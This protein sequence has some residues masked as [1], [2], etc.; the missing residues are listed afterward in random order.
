MLDYFLTF[1]RRWLSRP[2]PS[3]MLDVKRILEGVGLRTVVVQTSI[4]H[5][6]PQ[7]DADGK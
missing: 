1:H 3:E 2:H 7:E 5:F 4:G 6:G